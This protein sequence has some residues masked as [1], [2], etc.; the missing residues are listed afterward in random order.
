MSNLYSTLYGSNYSNSGYYNSGYY[1]T[2]TT[3]TSTGTTTGTTGTSS[4]DSLLSSGLM[5]NS[6]ST[7]SSRDYG[8]EISSTATSL[9]SEGAQELS[10]RFF[11][12]IDKM[13]EDFPSDASFG[14]S[15]V[16][17]GLSTLDLL[18]TIA[19]NTIP[20]IKFGGKWGSLFQNAPQIFQ[21]MTGVAGAFGSLKDIKA[22]K[23]VE[24][25]MSS[26]MSKEMQNESSFIDEYYC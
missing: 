20:F 21:L 3:G 4:F 25:N 19:T 11:D 17:P 14:S 16:G 6:Y 22:M 7:A 9:L 13:P 2:G 5:G 1:N 26:V 23:P 12:R 8:G 10:R 24:N 18:T 15:P